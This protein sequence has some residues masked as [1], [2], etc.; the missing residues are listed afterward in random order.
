MC[1]CVCVCVCVCACVYV[2]ACMCVYVRVCACVYF[3]VCAY[4][5]RERQAGQERGS[6]E[7][8]ERGQEKR[9][10][11]CVC[12]RESTNER[13]SLS[14]S[15]ACTRK[16][17]AMQ[18]NAIESERVSLSRKSERVSLSF[19]IACNIGGEATISRLRKIIGLF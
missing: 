7:V 2:R 12:A 15:T 5:D 17:D 18:C 13:D 4:R 1:E 3:Y 19:S 14:F 11:N 6:N 9:K 10:R 16:R 8:R